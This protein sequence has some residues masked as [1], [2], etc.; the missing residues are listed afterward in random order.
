MNMHA[1]LVDENRTLRWSEVPAP[2]PKENEVLI[3]VHAAAL[4]R[5]DLLQR[6]GK[7]PP[8][9]GWPEWMGLEVAGIILRAPPGDKV[10]ALLG[11]GGYAEKVAVPQDMIL[12]VPR[13]FSFEEAAAI[14][15]VFA[16]A[17]LNL[18]YEAELKAGETIF[19]QAGASGLGTA[20]IQVAKLM[21]AKA[22]T[23][24]GADDKLEFVRKLG[25][26]DAVNRKTENPGAVRPQ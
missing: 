11:G 15:E 10:C 22:V 20:A 18:H 26:D 7:Y 17:W 13:G 23:S 1:M 24:A 12:P 16:T 19:I 4:N 6:A 9:P 5:A 8:P 2:A 21:G 25:A 3:E 14:P